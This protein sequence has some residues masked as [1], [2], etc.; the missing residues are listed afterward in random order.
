MPI[1]RGGGGG[2]HVL[3][4]RRSAL[5]LIATVFTPC[6]RPINAYRNNN[7]N[8]NKAVYEY[9][10][11]SSVPVIRERAFRSCILYDECIGKKHARLEFS[12]GHTHTHNKK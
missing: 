3:L 6:G 7:N 12:R 9:A 1:L 2:E 5:K 8:N 11:K 10:R 4:I